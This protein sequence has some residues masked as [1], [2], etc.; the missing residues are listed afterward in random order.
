M[1]DIRGYHRG[2]SSGLGRLF[3]SGC[4]IA[5]TCTGASSETRSPG[6]REANGNVVEAL[7]HLKRYLNRSSGFVPLLGLSGVFCGRKCPS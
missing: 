7:D 2:G 4:L 3:V 5:A 6:H 1:V